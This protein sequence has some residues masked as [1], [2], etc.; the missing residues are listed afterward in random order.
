MK[1]K[2]RRSFLKKSS[3]LGAGVFIVP[4]DVIGGKGFI[5]PSDRLNIAAIGAGG[6]GAD[7]QHSWASGERVIALC[8]VHPNGKHGVI[9]SRNKYP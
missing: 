9:Q 3:I 8:D 2:S 5:P 4:R 7:I 6:K 1:K